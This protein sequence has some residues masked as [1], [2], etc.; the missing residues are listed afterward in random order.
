MSKDLISECSK[1]GI[2]LN[3]STM[4][5][6]TCKK[7]N[8]MKVYQKLPYDIQ[9]IILN[10]IFSNVKENKRE[11]LEELDREK[12]FKIYEKEWMKYFTPAFEIDLD[13]FPNEVLVHKPLNQK[14][15]TIIIQ[16]S[17]DDLY[18]CI[19]DDIEYISHTK[20]IAINTRKDFTYADIV[21]ILSEEIIDVVDDYMSMNHI[22]IYLGDHR[23]LEMLELEKIESIK[24]YDTYKLQMFMG[25]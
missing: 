3:E 25:S 18:Y 7:N 23:F 5:Y 13:V 24:N 11:L 17:L 6:H 10:K 2:E 12:W 8:S 4:K 19:D 9:E 1:C 15:M 22:E 20:N 21:Q 16:I 14:M